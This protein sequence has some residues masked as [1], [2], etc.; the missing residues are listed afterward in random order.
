M[1]NHP[2][3]SNSPKK[4]AF[5]D[6]IIKKPPLPQKKVVIPDT[7]QK[8]GHS[9]FIERTNAAVRIGEIKKDNSDA[10]PKKKRWYVARPLVILYAVVAFTLFLVVVDAFS[11]VHVAITPHQEFFKVDTVLKA[12]VDGQADL[13]V[14]TVIMEESLKQSLSVSGQQDVEEKSSGTLTIYNE[15]SS[16]PQVFVGRTR[17]ETPDGKIYR[18]AEQVTVPGAKIADGK[19]E[20]SSLDVTVY[21]DEPGEEYN[22]GPAD[23]TIPGFKGSPRYEKFYARSSSGMSGGFNGTTRVATKEDI[24]ALS[25][26]LETQIREKLARRLTDELPENMIVPENAASLSVVKKDFSAEAGKPAETLVLDMTMRYDGLAVSVDD[27]EELLIKR[28]LEQ[29]GENN[30]QFD[31]VNIGNLS[32]QAQESDPRSGIMTLHIEGFAHVVWNIDQSL[33]AENLAAA[34]FRKQL[35]VFS[36]YPQIEEAVISFS[37]SWWRVFPNDPDKITIER[38]LFE[39][40]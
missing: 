28:Y 8:K 20:P 5:Q 39:S 6:I 35:N 16:A 10:R 23:F 40:P 18:I 30:T 26:A 21:A 2:H 31:I 37:P 32:Y 36:Y 34:G 38:T 14:E 22:I 25:S 15:F 1:L 17:F 27:L 33:L 12:S 13:G 9:L 19:I 24:D 3:S 7:F 29:E 4:S 11:G